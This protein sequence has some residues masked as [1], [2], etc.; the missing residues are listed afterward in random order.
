LLTVQSI[1]IKEAPSDE[2]SDRRLHLGNDRVRP[3]RAYHDYVVNH[4]EKKKGESLMKLLKASD[5]PPFIG[6]MDTEQLLESSRSARRGLR[7]IQAGALLLQ[8]SMLFAAVVLC[9]AAA[10][11]ALA[12]GSVLG[13]DASRPVS[14]AKRAIDVLAWG[15]ILLGVVGLAKGVF[16][17]INGQQG[18]AQSI[19]WGTGGLG[20]GFLTSWINSEVNGNEVA[21]PQP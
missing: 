5:L 19:G 20:F 14:L 1:N 13:N 3:L 11:P 15:M 7:F 17:G 18:W 2:G 21:L 12:Q 16:R 8:C 6:G 10:V 4:L 9:A